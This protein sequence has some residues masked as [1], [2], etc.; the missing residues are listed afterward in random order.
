MTHDPMCPQRECDACAWE[1]KGC[2]R[3]NCQCDLIAKVRA[4]TLNK[5]YEAVQIEIGSRV[6]DLLM[7]NKP[8]DCYLKG[9]GADIAMDDALGVID[10]LRNK[11]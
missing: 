4:D 10:E 5:V 8:D 6:T 11:L 1:G 7:C 9:L 3:G 2:C